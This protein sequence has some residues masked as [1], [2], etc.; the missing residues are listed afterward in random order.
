[1]TT[2]KA[3]YQSA[4]TPPQCR[5]RC[6]GF[7]LMDAMLALGLATLTILAAASL[8]VSATSAADAA[9]QN[10]IAYNAARQ[11]V[12]NLRQDQKARL[13]NG[14]YDS[15]A[16]GTVPFL[17]GPVPQL[18]RL[19]R[20][21]DA[22]TAAAGRAHVSISDY[23]ERVVSGNTTTLVLRQPVKVITVTITWRSGARGGTPRKRTLTTLVAPDGVTP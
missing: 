21:S 15:N 20:P 4:L 22:D 18:A 8:I 17:F 19:T 16:S 5:R 2:K 14:E 23:Y 3:Q 11:V 10:N 6:R 12:E 9:R 7:L 13:T 1:V